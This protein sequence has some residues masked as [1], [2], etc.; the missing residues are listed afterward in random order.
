MKT[1]PH[2]RQKKI[3]AT[4]APEGIPKNTWDE[5]L[6][7]TEDVSCKEI[8]DDSEIIDEVI[9]ESKL[10]QICDDD[11]DDDIE[12]EQEKPPS[13][14]EM[15]AVM[16]TIQRGLQMRDCPDHGLLRRF[17]D[18]LELAINESLTQTTLDRFLRE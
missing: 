16:R 7:I 4:T 13:A 17:E 12:E 11:D 10:N 8:I 1:G 6:Q 2:D 3:T 18:R 14:Q 5:W 15:R 9:S